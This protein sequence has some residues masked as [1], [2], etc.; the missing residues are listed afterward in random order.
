MFAFRDQLINF[1]VFEISTRINLII[2][3]CVNSVEF[4]LHFDPQKYEAIT[5][6]CRQTVNSGQTAAFSIH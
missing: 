3:K 4:V 2:I 1:T 6:H 5:S